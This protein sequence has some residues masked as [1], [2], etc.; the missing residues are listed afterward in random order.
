MKRRFENKT[1][2]I[3]GALRRLGAEMAKG[4]MKEGANLVCHFRNSSEN[5]SELVLLAQRSGVQVDF[6]R[7]DFTSAENIEGFIRQAFGSDRKI[8]VMIHNASWYRQDHVSTFGIQDYLDSVW[9]HAMAPA[10]IS[11]EFYQ[12][13]PSGAC[14]VTMLDGSLGKYQ[15]DFFSYQAGKR[16]LKDLTQQMAME[17]APTVRVNGLALGAFLPDEILPLSTFDENAARMPLQ[18]K[19]K[20]EELL[21]ALYFVIEN[22]YLTGN[23]LYLDGGWHLKGGAFTY[24]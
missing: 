8:D 11:R 13:A 12:R 18:R 2:L 4:L 6:L 24:V 20:I 10:L 21:H 17:F 23:I 16:L 5:Q 3:T 15:K 22:E 19:G 9:V 7:A 14:I 1:V